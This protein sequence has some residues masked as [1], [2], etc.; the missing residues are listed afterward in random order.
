MTTSSII[1]SQVLAVTLIAPALSNG[2]KSCLTKQ[3][4]AI[5]YVDIKNQCR[6]W[7]YRESDKNMCNPGLPHLLSLYVSIVFAN[8]DESC[9][10]LNNSR[11]DVMGLPLPPNKPSFVPSC[12]VQPCRV[13]RGV[14]G[15]MLSGMREAAVADGP[16]DPQLKNGSCPLCWGTTA[17]RSLPDYQGEN[18]AFCKRGESVSNRETDFFGLIEKLRS[19]EDVD[20]VDVDG[21]PRTA[22]E[23]VVQNGSRP[24]D[25]R[26]AG[27]SGDSENICKGV[28]PGK[29]PPSKNDGAVE[30]DQKPQMTSEAAEEVEDDR[31]E[32]SNED[33]SQG[34]DEDRGGNRR[35]IWLGPLLAALVAGVF[36]IAAA[37][38][39]K[40]P[41]HIRVGNLEGCEAED[42]SW[43][44]PWFRRRTA[45]EADPFD[46]YRQ[47]N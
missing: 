40:N 46:T 1:L 22:P 38:C 47:K 32:G 17:V 28:T 26:G 21:K 39:Q 25:D 34:L 14:V 35:W 6:E 9:W 27:M 37:R 10:P 13:Q 19:C 2:S 24:L 41:V 5:D 42:S 33:G 36:A 8:G 45:K 23:W 16:V 29:N 3:A 4:V 44:L 43:S 15:Y 20:F 12:C 31:P 18:R 7:M 30:G 11:I